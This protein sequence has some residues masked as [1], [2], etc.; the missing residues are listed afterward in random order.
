[1]SADMQAA[2]LALSPRARRE[3]ADAD[4]QVL[5]MSMGRVYAQTFVVALG[6]AVDAQ[7]GPSKSTRSHGTECRL[8]AIQDGER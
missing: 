2:F 5:L 1:M 8:E 4:A 7:T 6:A 3:Q